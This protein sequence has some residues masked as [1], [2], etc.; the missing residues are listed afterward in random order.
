MNYTHKIG[1]TGCFILMLLSHGFAYGD[2]VKT[3]K[4]LSETT[5]VSMFPGKGPGQYYFL[6]GAGYNLVPRCFAI[7]PN[8]S[9]FYIPE[10]DTRGKIRVHKFDKTGKF[11]YMLNIEKEGSSRGIY[12]IVVDLNGDIYLLRDAPYK[13]EYLMRCDKGGKKLNRLGPEGPITVEELFDKDKPVPEEKLFDGGF[14]HF[15]VVDGDLKIVTQNEYDKKL[16]YWL[17]GKTGQKHK[18]DKKVPASIEDATKK[19][20]EKRN[21]LGNTHFKQ[22][23]KGGIVHS[24]ISIDGGFYYMCVSSDKLEIR[25][26]SFSKY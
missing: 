12:E 21:V 10:L 5:I 26:V 22:K 17:N 4:I 23:R 1:I 9:S 2:D 18:K 24:V 19:K 8:D 16:F 6:Q 15:S 13:D 20:K 7:D 3:P 25:R 14:K 11:I